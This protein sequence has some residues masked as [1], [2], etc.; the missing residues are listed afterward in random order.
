[1]FVLNGHIILGIGL[2]YDFPSGSMRS[3][4]AKVPFESFVLVFYLEY[5]DFFIWKVCV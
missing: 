5:G 3:F 1:M 2:K 4:T